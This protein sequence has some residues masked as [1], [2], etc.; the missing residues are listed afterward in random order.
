MKTQPRIRGLAFGLAGLSALVL[1][2]G[3]SVAMA[4]VSGPSAHQAPALSSA[5]LA[6]ISL[7]ARG[8]QR[9]RAIVTL[10]PLL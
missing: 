7:R 6:A 10:F 9:A 3:G 8:V 1:A 5:P 4:Q 2:S